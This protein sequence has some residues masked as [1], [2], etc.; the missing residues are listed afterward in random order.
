M[1]DDNETAP[2]VDRSGASGAGESGGLESAGDA[3]TVG[4]A[5]RLVRVRAFLAP[6]LVF[7]G[8]TA[9]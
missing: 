5:T 6:G 9:P 2:A 4:S 3:R 7:G 1:D 8:A